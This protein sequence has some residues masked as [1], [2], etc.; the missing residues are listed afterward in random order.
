MRVE[1]LSDLRCPAD[2]GEL[3]AEVATDRDGGFRDGALACGRCAA[4]IPIRGGIPRFRQDGGYASSFGEQWN[5]YRTT[6]L[7]SRNGTTLSRDRFYSG[8]GWTPG[9]L[10]GARVLEVGCG[11]GRF[12]EVIL[13]AGASVCALDYTSAADAC[14]QNNGSHPNLCL[15]QGDLYAMPFER[16]SFDFVFCY[17]VLQHT[18]DPDAAFAAL[19][20]FLK[21]GGRLAIDV[22]LKG[23]ALEPYKSKYL[24]RPLTTR[25][26]T[27][28]LFK[29]LQWYIP[30]WLPIDTFIKKLPL[31]GPALG[32]IVP[33]W[34]YSALPLSKAL[35]REWSVLDT[36]DALAPAYDFPQTV[37]AVRN[38][39]ERSRLE[40]IDVRP[41]GNGVLGN[42]RM[43]VQ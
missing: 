3:A 21:P 7:D 30:K 13:A 14:Y 35:Q 1:W 27:D 43:R 24:Y 18:P 38:W 39:F 22:Y 33:C 17:G 25:I 19:V 2:G 37:E 36:F 26:P 32:M 10:R 41:G 40:A 34:N 42:G 31:V 8:T 9:A 6:Q 4:R 28:L 11:A 12:T 15:V 20:P 29:V 23:W 5:R 16:G